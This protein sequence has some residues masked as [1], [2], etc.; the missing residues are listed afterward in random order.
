M[1]IYS[2]DFFAYDYRVEFEASSPREAIEKFKAMSN[3]EIMSQ[4][5]LL[6]GL[7]EPLEPFCVFTEIVDSNEFKYWDYD[8]ITDN[9]SEEPY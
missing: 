2:V 7:H 5:E 3:Y 9:L 6:N 4:A 8:L 1:A